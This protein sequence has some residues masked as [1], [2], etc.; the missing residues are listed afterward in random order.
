R[1]SG[2]KAAGM[3]QCLIAIALRR[4]LVHLQPD[5]ASQDNPFIWLARNPTIRPSENTLSEKQPTKSPQQDSPHLSRTLGIVLE[6]LKFGP[7][8][9][10]RWRMYSAMHATL[11]HAGSMVF[12][13]L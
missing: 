2:G 1:K 7:F 13:D 8:A 12:D 5:V 3:V 10:A 11:T 4:R 6:Q 9:D